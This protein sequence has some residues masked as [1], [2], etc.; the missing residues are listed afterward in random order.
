MLFAFPHGKAFG[1][2]WVNNSCMWMCV[3][4]LH[5]HSLGFKHLTANLQLWSAHIISS[6][7][8]R[9]LLGTWIHAFYDLSIVIHRSF[10]GRTLWSGGL[11]FPNRIHTCEC[12]PLE[13]SFL[14]PI[15]FFN[16][17]RPQILLHHIILSS[18]LVTS[19]SP[20]PFKCLVLYLLSSVYH[21]LQPDALTDSLHWLF[22]FQAE[23]ARAQKLSLW[24]I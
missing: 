19:P 14:A 6:G 1:R 3:C 21:G 12:L 18:H 16:C 9:E 13:L 23:T 5:P 8:I 15:S 7:T 4:S 20:F 22:V 24:R 11:L 17:F 10:H 2:E